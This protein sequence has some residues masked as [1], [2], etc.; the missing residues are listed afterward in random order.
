MAMPLSLLLVTVLLLVFVT[1]SVAE[2]LFEEALVVK[3]PRGD[4]GYRGIMGDFIAL[5]DGSLLMSYTDG[6]IMVLRSTDQGKTWGKAE[7]LVK[8]PV[9]QAKA[10]IAHP[11]FLRLADGQILL[12]YI[13]ST[14]PAT[15]YFAHNYLR[16]S[17]DEGKTW[18]DPMCYTAYPGYVLVHNDRVSLLSTGRIMAAAEYKMYLPSSDDHSGF[19][20][21][22][23]YSDDNGVSWHPSGN[24]VDL[25]G[26]H[27]EVQEADV[28]ELKDGRLLM[29][30][31]T[32]SG[33][34][35]FAY[36]EDKGATWGP[37]IKRTDIRLPYAGLP[38]VRRMP[39]GDLLFIWITERS[40]DKVNPKIHR[41]CTLTAAISKDEGATLTSY[42]N[43]ASDPEDDFGYQCVE[44]VDEGTVLVG[45][46]CRDGIRVARIGMDWFYRK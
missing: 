36:S 18:S 29:F 41:R 5:K 8:R 46:H 37:G 34:P 45:Y 43:I 9:P 4:H 15:P 6:D 19:V 16:R 2:G 25:Y 3:K 1:Q 12:T 32:Y 13:Y 10:Y 21:L 31:R 30:A 28:V 7:V 44:F 24:V 20:G 39:N 33:F 14:H 11:S 23:F 40:Q 35:V 26:E 38:T 27:V 22:S 42:R 17:S